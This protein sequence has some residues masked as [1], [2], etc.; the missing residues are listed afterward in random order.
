MITLDCSVCLESHEIPIAI[1]DNPYYFHVDRH[2]CCAPCAWQWVQPKLNQYI[3]D[4]QSTKKTWDCPICRQIA[5]KSQ[6][7][8]LVKTLEDQDVRD[9]YLGIIDIIHS[10]K[11]VSPSSHDV[12]RHE[13]SNILIET[14]KALF[15][16]IVFTVAITV[17]VCSKVVSAVNE[18]LS[19]IT[20][21]DKQTISTFEMQLLLL[22]LLCA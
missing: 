6:L 1:G 4:S 19:E 22:P 14:I 2:Y 8:R 16:L 7:E 17:F 18:L 9:R 5:T 15:G 3:E 20:G 10:E 21:L 11:P 12:T 13:G